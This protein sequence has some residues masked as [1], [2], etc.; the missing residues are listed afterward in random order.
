MRR[1]VLVPIIGMVL[2][3]SLILTAPVWAACVQTNLDGTWRNVRVWSSDSPK[4][5]CWDQCTLTID[6]SGGITKGR[7]VSCSGQKSMIMGGQLN[8]S[9]DCNIDG[10]IELSDGIINIEIGGFAGDELILTTEESVIQWNDYWS[11][12]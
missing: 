1:I 10:F 12:Y 3:L 9:P 2:S 8:I 11:R 6:G 7:Y 5:Q 4:T